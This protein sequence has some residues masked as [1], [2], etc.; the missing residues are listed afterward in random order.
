M[1][2]AMMLLIWRFVCLA[3]VFVQMLEN[4]FYAMSHD[5]CKTLVCC[6]SSM[7]MNA[8]VRVRFFFMKIK[9]KQKKKRECIK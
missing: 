1:P 7:K 5:V 9:R 8:S 6:F 4:P 3:V 2:A